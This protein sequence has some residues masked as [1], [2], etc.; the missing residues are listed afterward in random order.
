MVRPAMS[1]RAPV[2]TMLVAFVLATIA[3]GGAR[4]EPQIKQFFR[5]SQL[6]DN[7]T[8]ANFSAVSFDPR[9]E[10]IVQ[11]FTITEVSQERR[12]PLR[13]RELA[14]AHEEAR[15]ADEAFSKRKKEYQDANREVIDR[16]LKAENQRTKLRGKD[17]EVQTAWAKWREETAAHSKRLSEARIKLAAERP[18]A[19]LSLE[20]PRGPVDVTQFEG[21]LVSKDVTVA[22]QVKLPD[23]QVAPKTLV[24]TMQR[25]VGKVDGKDVTGRWIITG[26]KDA[27]GARTSQ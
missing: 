8:L 23:G 4:E 25:A 3:C 11:S 12:Q 20:N 22:A 2:T 7:Q 26:V 1:L 13:L 10:G 27:A 14:K 9:T 16:V 19:E 24:I 15:A 5:A 21:D 6:R 17:A 18:I